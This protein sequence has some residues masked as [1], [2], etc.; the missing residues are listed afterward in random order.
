M[1]PCVR[2]G[3]RGKGVYVC[4]LLVRGKVNQCSAFNHLAK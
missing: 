3:Q 1:L 2:T 4:K